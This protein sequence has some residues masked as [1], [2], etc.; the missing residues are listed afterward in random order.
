MLIR[1]TSPSVFINL[2]HLSPVIAVAHFS[3]FLNDPMRQTS[4]SYAMNIFTVASVNC[5]GKKPAQ[6]GKC[7]VTDSTEFLQSQY[8]TFLKTLR[9]FNYN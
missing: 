8:V 9:I 2:I 3:L 6:V 4:L 1:S 5:F 7:L